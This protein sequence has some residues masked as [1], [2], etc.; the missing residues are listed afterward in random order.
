MRAVAWS[1]IGLGI[2]V[3]AD[4]PAR[5]SDW[6]A[7]VIPG[8]AGVP[9]FINGVDVSYMIVE[10][11]YGLDRPQAQPIIIIPRQSVLAPPG[12]FP[13]AESSYFRDPASYHPRDNRTHGYGRYER[14]PPPDAPKPKP[15]ASYRREWSAG[16][17]PLPATIDDPNATPLTVEPYVDMWGGDRRR[18][19]PREPQHQG[20]RRPPRR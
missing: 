2:G 7:I 9:V 17:Q 3:L 12:Y 16:S 11:D 6:P 13:G 10:G 8:K 14:I 19:K 1:V 20:P 5:A 18:P 4:V 15:A